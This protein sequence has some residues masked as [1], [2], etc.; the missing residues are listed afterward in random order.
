MKEITLITGA[1]SGIGYELAKICSKNGHDLILVSRNKKKLEVIKKEFESKY[2]N[3][4]YVIVQDLSEK[5]CG[6]KVFQ[7]ASKLKLKITNL[8]NNSGYG[9]FGE[10]KNLDLENE[11]LMIDL[12]CRAVVDLTGVFLNQIIENKGKILNVAST[13]A[14][15]SL[16]SMAVYGSTKSFVL[17]FSYALRDEVKKYGV[18]VTCLCPGATKTQFDVNAGIKNKFFFSDKN[19]MSAE[20]VAE[21]GFN[22]MMKRKALVVTGFQNKI[23]VFFTRFL[24]KSFSTKIAGKLIQK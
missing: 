8:I 7:K 3:K 5:N 4:V 11:L 23:G 1:T 18:S 14:F 6:K 20:I 22:A 2:K 19:V 13:A 9:S 10:F 16:P 17:S 12:N 24:T 21:L 15:Q